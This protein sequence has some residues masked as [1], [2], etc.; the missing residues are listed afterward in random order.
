M[1]RLSHFA[2]YEFVAGEKKPHE[3][4]R[5]LQLA[6]TGMET[7]RLRDGFAMRLPGQRWLYASR[8]YVCTDPRHRRG[9]TFALE[10]AQYDLPVAHYVD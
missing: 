6:G 5:P 3:V 10:V 2:G 9:T 4:T 8:L 7:G 1:T